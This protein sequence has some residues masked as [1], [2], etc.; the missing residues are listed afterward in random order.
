VTAPSDNDDADNST[1]AKTRKT[2]LDSGLKTI[3]TYS[4]ICPRV[5]YRL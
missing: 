3:L 5:D 4:A 1:I 2:V